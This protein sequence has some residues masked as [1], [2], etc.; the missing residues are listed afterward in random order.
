MYYNTLIYEVSVE[1]LSIRN[2]LFRLEMIYL[3]LNDMIRY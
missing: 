2:I 3:M 1:H